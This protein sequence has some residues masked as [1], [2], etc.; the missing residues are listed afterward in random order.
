M[1]RRLGYRWPVLLTESGDD[2]KEES[3]FEKFWKL[4]NLG[5][6]ESC[7]FRTRLARCL[8]EMDLR[9][10]ALEENGW[11]EALERGEE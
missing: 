11:Q 6:N 10:K 2:M 9:I 1:G 5:I 4:Q 3:E 8:S 7:E